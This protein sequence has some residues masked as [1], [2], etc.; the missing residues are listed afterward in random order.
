MW[1]GV[2]KSQDLAKICG[3]ISNPAD[4]AGVDGV[5]KRRGTFALAHVWGNSMRRIF[6]EAQDV[7]KY[8]RKNDCMLYQSATNCLDFD[9]QAWLLAKVKGI[10]IISYWF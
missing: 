1:L 3:R 10:P 9:D 5:G 2:H 6:P 8:L 7:D 4:D